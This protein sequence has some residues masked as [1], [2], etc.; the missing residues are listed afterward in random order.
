M[1]DER[2]R[3]QLLLLLSGM[4]IAAALVAFLVSV[5]RTGRPVE[6]N[7]SPAA[8]PAESAAL[9]PAATEDEVVTHE[10]PPVPEREDAAARAGV[11]AGPR[12]RLRVLDAL[13]LAP[14][15]GARA[16]LFD[17][18]EPVGKTSDADGRCELPSI[19]PTGEWLLVVERA[20]HVPFRSRQRWDRP[21][22]LQLHPAAVLRG[23]V[24]AADSGEP[25]AGAEVRYFQPDCEG[26]DTVERVAGPD[27]RFELEDVP[28]ERFR[29]MRISAAGFASEDRLFTLHLGDSEREHEIRL[30]RG[31]P[32]HGQV[33]DHTTGAALSGARVGEFTTDAEGRFRGA[34]LPVPDGTQELQ[35]LVSTDGYTKGSLRIPI[36][37]AAREQLLLLP[38]VAWLEGRVR[39]ADGTPVRGAEVCH[40]RGVPAHDE[41]GERVESSPLY[42]AEEQGF[43]YYLEDARALTD[44]DGR[45]RLAVVPWVLNGTVK[46]VADDHAETSRPWKETGAPG[47]TQTLDLQLFPASEAPLVRGQV[48]LNGEAPSAFEGLVSWRGPTRSG[49]TRFDTNARFEL[50][51]EPGPIELTAEFDALPGVRSEPSHFEARRNREHTLFPDVLVPEHPITGTV[52]RADGQGVAGVRLQAHCPVPKSTGRLTRHGTRTVSGADGRYSLRVVELGAPY[53]VTCSAG[54]ED[55]ERMALPGEDGIDFTV[56]QA[57]LLLVRAHAARTGERLALDREFQVLARTP[58]RGFSRLNPAGSEPDPAGFHAFLQLDPEVDLLALPY[59]D[60]V[61]DLAP[62]WQMRVELATGE[63]R[64]IEFLLQ[65][66]LTLEL[67]LADPSSAFPAE[68]ELYLVEE[69]LWSSIWHSDWRD[70]TPMAGF[71]TRRR[72]TFDEQGRAQLRALAPGPLRFKLFPDD[73]FITPAS[74][75]LDPGQPPVEV[76]WSRR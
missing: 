35:L 14:L 12:L 50:T 69:P 24:V 55:L 10:P 70:D 54:E 61:P 36:A 34:L 51:V 32:I 64:K 22:T 30:A 2:V 7:G 23:R 19:D 17:R 62:S 38:R 52:R 33:V 41:S 43:L 75:R 73:L 21:V 28:I 60:S 48:L 8:R 11:E 71:A 45:Y 3:R 27:G 29:V 44:A 13:T 26:C 6:R 67:E 47:A 68:H 53:R 76:H 20:G 4:A 59:G 56:P 1:R 15:A 66:G 46:V 42:E 65:P 57:G 72:V 25:L 5:W 39:A 63:P 31:V 16:T 9:V 37:N 49:R 58:G 18:A 74:F 40:A